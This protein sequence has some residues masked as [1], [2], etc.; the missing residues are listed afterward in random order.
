[1]Q[2][3]ALDA[4]DWVAP[5]GDQRKKSDD[6]LTFALIA[7]TRWYHSVNSINGGEK[8]IEFKQNSS[9]GGLDHE[10]N[11]HVWVGWQGNKISSKDTTRCTLH[12]EV[13]K[14]AV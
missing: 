11:K 1:M 4:V 7:L 3:N 6:G 13:N 2:K 12:R 14:K 8:V 9:R 10:V 5:C